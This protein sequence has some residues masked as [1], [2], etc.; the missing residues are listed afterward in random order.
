MHL[1]ENHD[2]AYYTWHD[3]GVRQ[4]ILIHVDAHHDMWWVS[5]KA[6]ITIANF[7]CSA[8]KE[9][10]VREVLW[11]V[12]DGTWRNPDSRKAVRRHLEKIAASYPAASP[13]PRIVRDDE[14]A[15]TLLGKTVR[16]LSAYSLPRIEETVLLDIDVDFM[17]IPWVTYGKTDHYRALP[18]CWPD[19]LLAG[20]ACGRVQSDL[21]TIAYSVEGGY[22]PLKWK[23]LGDEMALRLRQPDVAGSATTAYK[24]VREASTA[25]DRGDNAIGEEKYQQAARLLPDSAVCHY[26]LAHLFMNLGRVEEGQKSY[27]CALELDP[28]YRTAYSS[29]GF[30]YYGDKRFKKAEKEHL[31]TLALDPGDAYVHLG[32]GQLAARRRCWKEAETLL[33]R[34]LALNN[35]LIDSYRELG[36]VLAKQRRNDE[37]ILAYEHSLKLA[38][39][40]HR[41]VDG[42]LLSKTEQPRLLDPGHSLTHVR[43]AHLYTRKGCIAEAIAGYRMGAVGRNDRVCFRLRLASLYL[44]RGHTKHA[45]S[46]VWRALN[47]IPSTLR[48]IS[49]L[50]KNPFFLHL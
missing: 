31:R 26:H 16:I 18:W 37:A 20:L 17:V 35:N 36:H 45:A 19:Q 8:L 5:D 34:S 25:V 9:D 1:A 32:L 42:A 11:V 15:F 27:R 39:A 13:H 3:A 50:L 21:V 48:R 44:K 28:S 2:Q 24:L 30:V 47:L 29:R 33:R 46:E 22:T 7:I 6:P 12:P 10:I 41:P 49:S 14:I 4:R 23:Y 43:L 38:L 40:G